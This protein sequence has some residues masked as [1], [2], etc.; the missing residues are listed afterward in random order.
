MDA[1][2][3]NAVG[4]GKQA[5]SIYLETQEKIIHTWLDEHLFGLITATATLGRHNVNI[6]YDSIPCGDYVDKPFIVRTYLRK[7]GGLSFNAHKAD[8]IN[9]SW[10]L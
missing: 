8:I 5:Y 3:M 9:I 6:R 2:L 10:T 4:M 7:I 1:R